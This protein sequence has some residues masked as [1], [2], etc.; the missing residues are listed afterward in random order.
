MEE[1]KIKRN[2]TP[3]RRTL[4]YTTL[5]S[6]IITFNIFF[7]IFIWNTYDLTPNQAIGFVS[8]L[9]IILIIYNWKKD[10]LP[11]SSYIELQKPKGLY[12]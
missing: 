11:N 9:M 7:G 5:I 3:L 10:T 4:C 6:F 1:E 2:N 12:S 8:F